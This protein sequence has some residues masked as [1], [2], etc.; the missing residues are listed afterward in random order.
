MKIICFSDSHGSSYYMNKVLSMH[1]DAEAVFFLGDGL[2]DL[3]RLASLH[4]GVCFLPV[5]GNCDIQDTFCDTLVKK[6]ECITLM[7]KR[8]VYTHGD[9]YG[10]KYGTAG[11]LK[12]A[13]EVCADIVLF[14]HT[15]TPMESYT[16]T[17]SG[18]GVYLFNP[19]S[20]SMGG[21]KSEAS[22]G[23]IMLEDSGVL[24]SHGTIR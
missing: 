19:G 24:F 3:E 23:V 18:R 22:F 7:G 2:A 10:A 6:T 5:R 9:L 16:Q 20:V 4:V 11:L 14:G 13:D 21:F 8:I 17:E 12:L 15:H 1:P